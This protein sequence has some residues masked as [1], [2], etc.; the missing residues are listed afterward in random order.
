MC[1]SRAGYRMELH[2]MEKN[3]KQTTRM[4]SYCA[5]H[6]APNPDTVLIM[7][8][9]LGV[10]STK[11]LLQ[12]KRKAGSRLISSKRIKVEDTSPAENTRHEPFSAARCRIYRRTNH[13]K[14]RAAGEAIAH[15]V[16]GHYHHPLDAIQSLN[17]D[18]MVDKPPA[19]SSFRER[20]H[21]L[22]RTENERVFFGRSG[23]HGWG[24]FARQ[25]IQEGEMVLEYRGEQVRRSIADLREARYRLEGKDCYLFKISEEVVVDAT[26]KGNIARLIN[27]SCMPNCYA[28]IMSVGDDESRIVLI[29]KTD[30]S[31]GD[32]LTYDYLFDPDEPDEFKVPCLCKASNCRKFMN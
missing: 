7:Q 23:I 29:A 18:R 12:T 14:K 24:L 20:L 6:R 25:N 13:T 26:D 17:A 2:C 19:F 28:R 22:Q 11:S 27:H 3:G 5:Y 32:E 4:V 30:V 9:P 21:H 8:T 10:I 1:A 16:R 31:T 15:H